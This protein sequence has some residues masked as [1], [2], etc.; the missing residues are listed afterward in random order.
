MSM[1]LAFAQERS[2][3]MMMTA[4]VVEISSTLSWGLI[5]YVISTLPV[6]VDLLEQ[7]V[8]LLSVIGFSVLVL[9]HRITLSRSMTS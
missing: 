5:F 7:A 6:V 4:V 8:V 1:A 3:V 9:H 2:G